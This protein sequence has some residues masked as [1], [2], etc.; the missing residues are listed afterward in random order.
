[1]TRL[2][3]ITVSIKEK[4]VCSQNAGLSV[5]S[6][7]RIYSKLKLSSQFTSLPLCHTNLRSGRILASPFPPECFTKRD[8]LEPDRRLMSHRPF[9]LHSTQLGTQPLHQ[10]R[11]TA[12]ATNSKLTANTAS[13]NCLSRLTA[14]YLYTHLRKRCLVKV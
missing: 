13:E 1:M 5:N 9:F 2:T 3:S 11:H 10:V 4:F 7:K 6:N 14:A 12:T 8:E